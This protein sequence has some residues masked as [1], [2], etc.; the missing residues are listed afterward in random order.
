MWL[1]VSE[2]LCTQQLL[3][4]NMLQVLSLL[5]SLHGMGCAA[6]GCSRVTFRA[7]RPITSAS[8]QLL[9]RMHELV[10]LCEAERPGRVPLLTRPTEVGYARCD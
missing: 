9:W 3:G 8:L 1:R 7:V 4:M 6:G 10:V 5:L 2:A